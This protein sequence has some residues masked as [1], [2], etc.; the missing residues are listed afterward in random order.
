MAPGD[1]SPNLFHITPETAASVAKDAGAK[2]LALCH[3]D[4]AK[5]PTLDSR[6]TARNA[7]S[8]IFRETIAANDHTVIEI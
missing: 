7:A 5:Y 3:F 1:R 8:A 6:K 4:P 2:R